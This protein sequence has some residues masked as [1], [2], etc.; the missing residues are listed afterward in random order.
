M[1]WNLEEDPSLLGKSSKRYRVDFPA[2]FHETFLGESNF[3][4]YQ[5]FIIILVDN[6]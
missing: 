1:G 3:L 6:A 5:S 2:A 4:H